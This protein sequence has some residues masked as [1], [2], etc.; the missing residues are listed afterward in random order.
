MSKSKYKTGLPIEI[1]REICKLKDDGMKSKYISNLYDI[2]EK[3]IH[4]LK[5]ERKDSY[6]G[7]KDYFVDY[8]ALYHG[9]LII[10]MGLKEIQ[11]I[12]EIL[13]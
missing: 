12:E 2:P 9:D 13:N 7:I 4:T 3:T 11:L 5:P 8:I 6:K 10:K 1:R